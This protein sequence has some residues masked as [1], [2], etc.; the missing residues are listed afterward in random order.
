D[1]NSDYQL[2][3]PELQ[4]TPDRARASALGIPISDIANTVSSLVGGVA[5]GQYSTA[6]RRIDVRLRVLASQRQTPEDIGKLNVRS[7]TGQMIPINAVTTSQE[8][9]VL[10]AINH[11]DRE[12]AITIS[13]N[14]APGH[15]QTEVLDYVQS[16]AKDVPLGY[17]I[18]LSGQSSSFT[19]SMSS[20]FFA[21][22]LGILV[23]YMVLAS[24]FN[25]FMH[26]VTVLT[27]LPL[28][29]AG[30][31]Y[32]LLIMHKTVNVF[33]MIGVLLLMG[34]VKKNS[35]ILVDYATQLRDEH[36]EMSARE[37]ISKAG[38]IRLRPILMTTVATMMAA[39]PSSLGLGPG[40]ETRGPMADAVLG[41]L[42]LSTPLSL[43][44]VPSFYV[45]FDRWK[46][47][48]S[49]K[50]AEAP[51]VHVVAAAHAPIDPS[52]E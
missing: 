9:P 48:L 3:A 5:V 47:K 10:Q 16:L 32:A 37:A 21:L 42:I 35:I 50:K 31:A 6:G 13:G 29:V 25:S 11:A 51:V 20:L 27:I 4:I 45:I 49:R 28:S 22:G 17:R 15:A 52:A 12:R 23:A 18:V 19:D 1:L 44:V 41:G 24:Q 40:S 2:G 43:V 7:Q 46:Q 34:I 26:P 36:P 39:V 30:A 33:S 14:V 38:P 8:M